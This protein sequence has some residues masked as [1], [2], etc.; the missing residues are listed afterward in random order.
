MELNREE[1][2]KLPIADVKTYGNII[3]VKIID[4]LEGRYNQ[5]GKLWYQVLSFEGV[6]M[7]QRF[8]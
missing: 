5:D 8:E 3:P 1:F 6:L 2:F 7:R 4:R